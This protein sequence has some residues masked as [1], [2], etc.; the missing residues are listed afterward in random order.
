MSKPNWNLRVQRAKSLRLFRV[1]STV[2]A[3]VIT[4]QKFPELRPFFRGSTSTRLCNLTYPSP[5]TGCSTTPAS[6]SKWRKSNQRIPHLNLQCDCPNLTL[7][8]G[9]HIKLPCS[10][11]HSL[12]FSDLYEEKLFKLYVLTHFGSRTACL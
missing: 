9:K 10:E 5:K 1:I 11:S 3:T 12:I 2:Y 7:N 4:N 6:S 8:E